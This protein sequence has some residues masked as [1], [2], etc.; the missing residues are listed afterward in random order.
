MLKENHNWVGVANSMAAKGCS[1]TQ[2]GKE[3]LKP[4]SP[5]VKTNRSTNKR[6]AR[7]VRVL[8]STEVERPTR[9]LVPW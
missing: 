3:L 4:A 7:T 8:D 9:D 1:C 6:R 5:A 2:E